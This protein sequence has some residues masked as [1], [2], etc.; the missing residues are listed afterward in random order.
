MIFALAALFLLAPLHAGTA[1]KTLLFV[2]EHDILYRSGTMRRLHPLTKYEGNPVVYP[3]HKW[4]NWCG[5]VSVVRHPETGKFQMWYQGYSGKSNTD[6]RLKSVVCYAESDDGLKWVK[7]KLNL[8]P[9]YETKETNIVLIGAP[10]GYGDRYCNSVLY[11]ARDP[12]PAR[13]YKMVYYDWVSDPGEK[14]L[15]GTHVAFSP[16]GIHWT[17]YAGNPVLPTLFGGKLNPVPYADES[18]YVEEPSSKGIRRSWRYQNSL[19]D[20]LDVI[21]DPMRQCYAVYGKMWI[22]GPDGTL[23]WKHAMGRSES[24][25]FL[26]WSEPELLLTTN[27]NDPPYIEFHT[28]PVFILHDMYLCINQLWH[29]KEGSI[30]T[31]FMSSRDGEVWDRTF[32]NQPMIAHGKGKVFDAGSLFTNANPITVGDE[33][34]FYYAAHRGIVAS[35]PDPGTK[36]QPDFRSGI[37]MA[38][39]KRDRFIG[40]L[41]DPGAVMRISGPP[42]AGTEPAAPAEPNT[43]GQVTLRP[44]DLTGVRELTVNADAAK[45]AVRVEILSEDGYRLKGFTKEDAVPLSGNE[46]TMKAAWKAKNLG[47]LPSGK[48][49]VR[50]HLDNAELF[51]CTLNL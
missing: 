50:F 8:F 30:G 17:K 4:D 36:P 1:S 47:D 41:P 26:H 18:V 48:Y 42:K 28:S 39:T 35:T 44:L 14:G 12:D 20:A 51:A 46:L 13:R 22:N 34:W 9:Y 2:D 15:A 33:V 43:I 32:A 27:D 29:R 49:L 16:D 40:I 10:E 19:S 23:G 31:E 6:K 21:Y 24:K 37:G 11:D 45:G 3:E 7:P 5:W 25:D 38:K